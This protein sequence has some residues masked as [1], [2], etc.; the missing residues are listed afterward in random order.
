MKKDAKMLSRRKEKMTAM[1]TFAPGSCFSDF[2][3]KMILVISYISPFKR[4]LNNVPNCAQINTNL[5]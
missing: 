1:E 4:D 2:S 3:E 5:Q